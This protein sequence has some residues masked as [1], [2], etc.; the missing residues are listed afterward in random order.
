MKGEIIM[1]VRTCALVASSLFALSSLAPHAQDRGHY[2]AKPVKLVVSSAPGTPTDVVARILGEKLASSLGQPV[3]VDNRPGAS[4]TLG[5]NSVAKAPP[6]GYTLGLLAMT[7]LTAPALIAKMPYD[8]EKDLLAVTLLTRDSNLLV[9]PGTSSIRS[10]ADLVAAAKARPGVLKFA[11]GGNSSPAHLAGELF[12]QE[13]GLDITHIPYKGAV[14]GISGV[15]AGE[16][17][18]MFAATAAASPLIKAGRLRVVAASTPS[19]VA[20]F[21]DVPTLVELGYPRVAIAN[22]FGIVVPAG[23]P[24]QIVARL[25]AELQKAKAIPEVKQRLEAMG[26]EL[27]S[28]GPGEFAALIRSDT[29]K[30]LKVA[31]DAGIRPD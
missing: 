5:M 30:W 24:K 9:V 1:V 28:S 19:R 12:K 16:V 13:A 21:G 8:T 10:L 22:W 25:D 17:D 20:G 26:L 23:T 14:A 11:S 31:R 2:P 27:V 6:D 15:L 18:L 29:Q 7:Y 3:I 4:G